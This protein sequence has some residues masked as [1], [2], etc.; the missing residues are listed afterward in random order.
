MEHKEEFSDSTKTKVRDVSSDWLTS[1]LR[2]WLRVGDVMSKDVVTVCPDET[3]VSA[4]K[5]IS[6]NN[7][8]CI[9]VVDNGNVAGI[10]TETDFLKR[11][12]AEGKDFDEISVKEVM[13]SPVESIGSDLSVFEAS[14]IMDEKHIKRV[15]VLGE[16]RLV[17]IVTQTDLIRVSASYGMWRNVGEIMS[18]D[19]VGIQSKATVVEAT[20]VMTGCS[21]SCIVVL[22]GDEVVGV[23]TEKDLLKR[24][25]ALRKDPAEI[26]ME[27]LMSSPVMTVPPD[28]TVFSASRI[29]EKMDVRR[30]V[31]MENKQL[32]GI[33]TQTDILKAVKKKLQVDI[34]EL[35]QLR[36]RLKT[37]QSFAGIVGRD[38][39]M[40]QLFDTIREVAEV[41]IPVL[42]QGESGTGKELVA[43]AIHNESYGAEEPF[44]PVNCGAL[45]EGV[46]ES[47]L[48]GH[49]KG[50]FTG[51]VRDRKGRFELADG[52]TIFLDEVGE[53]PGATQVK[54]LR[55]LQE[56]TFQRVGGE[57]TIKVDVRVISAT[58]K[59]LTEEVAA[60]RF[61]EDLFYR[62]CVVPVYLPPL[63]ERRND[64]PLLAEHLLKR[65][66][67][68]VDRESVVL[69][70][71]AVDVMMDYDWPGNV[72]ELENAIRYALVKCRDNL[73]LPGYLP[74]KILKSHVPRELYPKKPGKK[75]KR[76]LDAESVWLAL[77]EAGGSKIEAARRL[78]VSRATLYRFLQKS[79]T[80]KMLDSVN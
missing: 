72:R 22:K 80:S 53:L 19:V 27:E 28:C 43:A 37:E 49:V 63:R 59:N 11:V 61:R 8:S 52:G 64:I 68:E 65:A 6:E 3:V 41:N 44:V 40:L 25:V 24:V 29:M 7:I 23:L 54:L 21:I 32:R 26:K 42:I 45:P 33:V 36:S 58:N 60:G 16:G 78:G 14:R 15:P 4:A 13:S 10:L 12:V 69:S 20:E 75:R 76:K 51:A 2:V 50:A 34:T 48:F 39:K 1:S 71:E 74:L 35:G 67:A 55:V 66:L 56:G 62:L 30:L 57:E 47:E 38:A 31:I 18:R 9:V 17:G 79:E 77:E 70:P 5:M 73:L 46:L